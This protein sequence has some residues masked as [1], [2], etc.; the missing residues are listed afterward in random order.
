MQR[1]KEAPITEEKG[2]RD[3]D[4]EGKREGKRENSAEE[5]TQGKYFPKTIDREYERG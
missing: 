4:R 3:R 5:I 1:G 2:E